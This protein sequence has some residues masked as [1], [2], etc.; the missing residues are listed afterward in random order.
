M[1][2]TLLAFVLILSLPLGLA[3]QTNAAPAAPAPPTDDSALWNNL[4]KYHGDNTQLAPAAGEKR[5]IFFG[6]SITDAWR[7]DAFFPGKNYVNRGISGQTTAQ[8]LLRFREDVI[9]LRP[10]VVVILAGTNDIAQ[11]QGPIPMQAIEDNLQSVAELCRANGAQTV[12]CSVL[13]A[14][15][16]GWHPGLHP[17]EKIPV[18]NKWIEAMCAKKHFVFLNYYPA[19]VASNGGMKPELS[20]D[21]V[22]P[23][24]AGYALMSP[25]ASAAIAQALR[26]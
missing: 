10:A 7:G 15:E 24:A 17:A 25:L 21:G 2:T 20:G 18:L 13:P 9:R 1:K 14:F 12:L 5:V 11:N 26:R 3:A 4:T 16:Y 19:L 8:M 6:D 22:H 23:N